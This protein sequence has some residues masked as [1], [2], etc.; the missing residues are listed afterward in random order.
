[1]PELDF[2]SKEFD[3]TAWCTQQLIKKAAR[4]RGEKPGPDLPK[5]EEL[6]AIS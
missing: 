6:E 2:K 3:Y 5:R 1:M 4:Y